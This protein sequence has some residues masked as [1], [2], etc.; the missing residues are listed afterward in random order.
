MRPVK[1]K[2]NVPLGI[3]LGLAM[4]IGLSLVAVFIYQAR[5]PATFER[6]GVSLGVTVALYVIGGIVGGAVFGLLLPLTTRRWGAAAVGVCSALPV[7]LAVALFLETSLYSGV[8]PAVVVGAI[9]GYVLWFPV[10]E[11]SKS[12]GAAARSG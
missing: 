4:A 2:T 11:N 7:Y 6:L 9:A 3:I 10:S 12:D 1:R 8:I 5:G